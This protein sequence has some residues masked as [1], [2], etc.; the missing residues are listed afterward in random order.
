M[1]PRFQLSWAWDVD[2]LTVL[3]TG[4]PQLERLDPLADTD[5]APRPVHV[6]P[7]IGNQGAMVGDLPSGPCV[8]QSPRAIQPVLDNLGKHSLARLGHP[9]RQVSVFTGT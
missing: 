7:G 1:T 5:D 3:L 8:I 6:Q 9:D 4:P 2:R